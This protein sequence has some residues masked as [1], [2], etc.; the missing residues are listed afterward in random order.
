MSWH[1]SVEFN[2]PK[3]APVLEIGFRGLKGIFR[4]LL[5]EMTAKSSAEFVHVDGESL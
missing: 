1:D 3:E 5:D 2:S 4:D